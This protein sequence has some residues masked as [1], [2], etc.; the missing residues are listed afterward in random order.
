M[1]YDLDISKDLRD[2]LES[3]GNLKLVVE[4]LEAKSWFDALVKYIV[5]WQY[6]S[7]REELPKWIAEQ[8]LPMECKRWANNIKSSKLSDD[9][10]IRHILNYVHNLIEYKSDKTVWKVEEKW[11][12]AEETIRKYTGDCED[13]AILIYLIAVEVGIPDW[14]LKVVAGNVKGGG[15]CWVNYLADNLTTYPIDWCYWFTESLKMENSL[16]MRPDYYHGEKIWFGFNK[17]GGYKSR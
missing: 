14:K 8:K 12:T 6:K 7:R 15:H 1:V 11:Q 4:D 13:G 3:E 17:T 2:K 16:R 5:D 9:I 10:K